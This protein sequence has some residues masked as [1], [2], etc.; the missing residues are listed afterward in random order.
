ML[1]NSVQLQEL[2]DS[3]CVDTIVQVQG[4]AVSFVRGAGCMQL[5]D[6]MVSTSVLRMGWLPFVTHSSAS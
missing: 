1:R 5:G 2:V 6:L 3:L 4:S